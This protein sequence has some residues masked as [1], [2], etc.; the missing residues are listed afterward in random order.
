MR[1]RV[2]RQS[3]IETGWAIGKTGERG[4]KMVELLIFAVIASGLLLA[5]IV[6][7]VVYKVKTHSKK[8]IF[9]IIDEL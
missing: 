2:L 5:H 1:I 4:I 6:A 3:V 8:S 9:A 7:A